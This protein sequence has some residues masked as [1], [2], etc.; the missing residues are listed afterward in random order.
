[1][2]SNGRRSRSSRARFADRANC[3]FERVAFEEFE[4]AERFDVVVLNEILYYFPLDIVDVVL[5]R[6]FRMLR[7]EQGIGTAVNLAARIAAQ[8]SGGQVLAT[9]SAATAAREAGL[10]VHALGPVS[11]K[12]LRGE[13]ELFAIS[14]GPSGSDDVIDPVCRMRVSR[15]RAAAH[16]ELGDT[17]YWFC[18][19]ECLKRFAEGE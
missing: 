12:N 18:S 14:V 3:R 13:C 4:P 8:A 6:A 10:A 17:Q 9:A 2:F 11:L 1:M 16:L 19:R 15:E 7:D 5:T